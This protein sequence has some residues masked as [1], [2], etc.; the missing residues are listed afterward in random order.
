MADVRVNPNIE[1]CGTKHYYHCNVHSKDRL[2][3]IIGRHYYDI[4]NGKIGKE[5]KTV[6]LD[7]P[8]IGKTIALRSPITCQAVDENGECICATCYGKRLAHINEK[9]HAGEIATFTLTDP[10]TQK[11]LSAK[12]CVTRSLVKS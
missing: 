9:K 6:T 5:L 12:H 4:E 2:K 11:L 10:L 3:Q 8:I 1:D 7:S